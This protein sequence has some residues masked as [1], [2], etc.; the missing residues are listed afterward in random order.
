MKHLVYIIL[1]FTLFSCT[2]TYEK[3]PFEEVDKQKIEKAMKFANDF[4]QALKNGNFYEFA[5]EAIEELILK[6][7][8]EFQRKLYSQISTEYGQFLNIE[9]FE[10]LENTKTKEYEIYRFK[11]Y[12]K[13]S[14]EPLEIR[15][16]LNQENKIAGFWIKP[17]KD[18]LN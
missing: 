7:T 12:F 5:N 4:M 14:D 13:K 15:V 2:N 9:F 18:N 1:F 8:P 17:W 11:G 3:I 10:A 16:V 6:L